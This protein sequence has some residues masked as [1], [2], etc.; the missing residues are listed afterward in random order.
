GQPGGPALWPAVVGRLLTRQIWIEL[1]GLPGY[2]ATLGGLLAGGTAT[3]LA[4]SPRDFRPAHAA[5]GKGV[6]AGRFTLAGAALEADETE[7]PAGSCFDPW[8]RPTPTR[9]LAV[10]LH[11]FA[12]LP[13]V[14]QQGEP[15]AREALRL[16]LAWVD[17]FS[18][19]SP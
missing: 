12:W 2:G 17:H 3:T 4:T 13:D 9:A 8:A 5:R 6:L 14:M 7:Q 11:A 16:T 18:R 10:D 19:W 15:G 1:Y